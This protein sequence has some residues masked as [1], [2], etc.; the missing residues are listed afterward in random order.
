[1]A[2][3]NRSAGTTLTATDYNELR[4]KIIEILG[5]N[6]GGSTRGY[7]QATTSSTV[8]GGATTLVSA[9]HMAQLRADIVKAYVH[10]TADS[11]DLTVP[12]GGTD[13][14]KATASGT[15]YNETHNAY[16]E[17]INYCYDNAPT[18][19]PSQMTLSSN[20]AAATAGTNW[21]GTV[22]TT[23]RVTWTDSNHQRWF[24]NAG[25]QVRFHAAHDN[26]STSKSNDWQ[27]FLANKVNGISFG[28]TEYWQ[29]ILA[30]TNTFLQQNPDGVTVYQDNYHNLSVSRLV[31]STNV[32]DFTMN[33]VDADRGNIA[34][35][36]F[37]I[38]AYD[39]DVIGTTT[40]N[41]SIYYPTGSTTDPLLGSISTVQ[42]DPPTVTV[43]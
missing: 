1:M 10:I 30:S 18:A 22:T 2:I 36:Y 14:I 31:G 16:I 29:H 43:A 20:V 26:N 4:N 40:S 28:Y 24:F 42:L 39:E 21:N 12:S 6:S 5:P 7:G 15:D 17:A 35:T 34:N 13:L 3:S 8:A 25:G 37:W 9:T 32:M 38:A 23:H 19:N 33:F 27:Q 11:F 41:I